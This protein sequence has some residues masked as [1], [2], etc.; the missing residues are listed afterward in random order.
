VVLCVLPGIVARYGSVHTLPQK[1]RIVGGVVIYA[2][3]VVSK[4]TKILVDARASGFI[5]N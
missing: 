4:E 2:I 3:L 1:I 5:S